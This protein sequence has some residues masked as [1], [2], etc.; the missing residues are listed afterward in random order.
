MLSIFLAE[1]I[2]DDKI[3]EVKKSRL[4]ETARL[5][6]KDKAWQR[7]AKLACRFGLTQ[8]CR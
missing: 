1:T 7:L 4:I 8:T 5:S 2:A 3:R 6:R